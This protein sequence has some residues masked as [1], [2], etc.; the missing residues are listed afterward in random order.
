MDIKIVQGGVPKMGRKIRNP[1][2]QFNIS[3]TP[4]A[5]TPFLLAPVLPGETMN[6][7]MLQ[8]RGV[9]DPIKNALIGW[10]TEYYFFYVKHRHMPNFEHFKNM[11]MLP[12]YNITPAYGEPSDA[13]YFHRTGIDW[14]GECMQPVVREYFRDEDEPW[15]NYRSAEGYSLAKIK[16]DSFLDS[17]KMASSVPD[18]A[19]TH[20]P[21]YEFQREDQHVMPGFEAHYAQWE[22]M[23]ALKM[24]DAT[25]EDW[26]AQFGIKPPEKE[27]ED[28]PELLRQ[29]I[30]W[31]YPVNTVEPTTGVPSSAVSWSVAERLDKA[32]SFNEPGFIFG[33]TVTRPKVY[34]SNQVSHGSSMLND[35]YS[36][37]PAMLRD[38]AYT[39][40]RGFADG[41]GPLQG[42]GGEYWV[43]VADL[44]HHGD[45]FINYPL[46]AE[47]VNFVP[48]P[49][50]A[51]N[52]DYVAQA[53]INT[54]FVNAGGGKNKAR[55]DGV[56]SL[57][58]K[59]A[60][61]DHT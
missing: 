14:V 25:Y 27:R 20:L 4:Y 48:V 22:H 54:L 11:V 16:N 58:I 59:S 30:N 17:A 7:A 15:D 23:R 37:L 2:H 49:G 5:I 19:D 32:R 53:N 12:G 45:Q 8:A 34:R 44:F 28:R 61:M 1:Q 50:T 55:Q 24:T 29:I 43:D 60:L 39:T 51:M 47:G 3:H 21:G 36:W 10:W 41:A 56:V 35:A 33:V 13:H 57:N 18:D 40:L 46:N 38:E 52:K 9:L 6:M 31:Q 42:Q 26:I